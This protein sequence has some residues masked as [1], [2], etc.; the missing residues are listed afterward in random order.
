MRYR[1]RQGQLIAELEVREMAAGLAEKRATL[2]KAQASL[3]QA[4]AAVEQYRAEAEFAQINYQRQKNIHDRDADGL[5]G[6]HVD[7]A[8][9]GHAVAA[10]KP[11][12]A[13]AR[14]EGAP[15]AAPATPQG[16]STR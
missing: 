12:N 7:Q 2:V 14:G 4:R 16:S 1:C 8:R 13:G 10:G 11:T 9:A 3:E 5:P 6:Q 15:A